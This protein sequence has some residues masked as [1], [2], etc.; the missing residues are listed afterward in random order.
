[1]LLTP[2]ALAGQDPVGVAPDDDGERCVELSALLE[3]TIF[4][5]DV[6]TLTV[7][8]PADVG[9]RAVEQ[10]RGRR[11]SEPLADS[12]LAIVLSAPAA[13]SRQQ[14]HRDVGMGRVLGGIRESTER[15]AE[16]GVVTA[17]YASEFNE[18]LPEMFSF[19]EEEET[20]EDDE[21]ML[22]LRGDSVR[23]VYRRAT[24][25]TA[26]DA[27]TVSASAR[28]GSVPAFF[29]PGSRFRRRLV[30]SLAQTDSVSTTTACPTIV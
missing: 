17:E 22:E 25:V 2:A 13:W 29:V 3:V 23:T 16:A 18:A 27:S 20:R 6:L 15:A 4:N 24:G 26:L 21:I 7:H 10:V 9:G 11:Y 30:E 1:M 14:F 12:V 28:R 5:I 8:L 19:L